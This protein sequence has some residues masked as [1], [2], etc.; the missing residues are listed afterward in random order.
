MKS[1]KNHLGPDSNTTETC[2]RVQAAAASYDR[3][4]EKAKWRIWRKARLVV[5][6]AS[7]AVHVTRRLVQAMD[8]Q[9]LAEEDGG[10]AFGDDEEDAELLPL[11]Y[12]VLDEAGALLEP[13]AMGC[14][15]HGARALLLVGDHHQLPPFTKWPGAEREHYNV[16][17]MER[18][19]RAAEGR[20]A[21][22]RGG[23]IRGG[24]GQGEFVAPA[25]MLTE[26]YRMHPGIAVA[27]SASFYSNRLTTARITADT[28]RHPFPANFVAV[29]GQEERRG[30][31]KSLTNEAEA[32]A[33]VDLVAGLVRA[34]IHAQAEINI[35]TF[36]NGQRSLIARKLMAAQLPQVQAISVDSMQGREEDVIVLSCVRTDRGGLGFLA[37]WRR[38]NVAVSRAK[39]QLIVVGD[40]DA[41]GSNRMWSDML[42]RLASYSSPRQFTEVVLEASAVKAW[43]QP[44]REEKQRQAAAHNHKII[45]GLMQG[46]ACGGGAEERGEDDGAAGTAVSHSLDAQWGGDVG[47]DGDGFWDDVDGGV[48]DSSAHGVGASAGGRGR[49]VGSGA[50]RGRVIQENWD[51]GWSDEEEEEGEENTKKAHQERAAATADQGN[52][53]SNG[54]FTAVV[55]QPTQAERGSRGCGAGAAGGGGQGG[56]EGD[57][58]D[59]DDDD[60]EALAD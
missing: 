7:S 10:R 34:G 5:C 26:Q 1:D 18:M 35:L 60:W 59:D 13:D 12:V 4:V 28:R 42:R 17:L 22:G 50:D 20:G 44:Y 30:G 16:S 47:G 29:R 57:D 56:G 21:G 38:V 15:L 24:R 40:P 25:F 23:G 52:N 14:L 54:S 51:D 43:V 45:M 41:L 6:T 2:E 32:N 46:L 19:A 48:D 37:D 3:C 58:Y 8:E 27:V 9:G 33:V 53:A 11:E 36:Y 55:G 49:E 39:E 31:S